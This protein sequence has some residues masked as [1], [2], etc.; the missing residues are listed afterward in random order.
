MSLMEMAEL[1]ASLSIDDVADLMCRESCPFKEACSADTGDRL[2]C[3]KFG[4]ALFNA[5]VFLSLDYEK[6]RIEE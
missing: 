4:T 5:V 6:T 2:V 1:I 3:N